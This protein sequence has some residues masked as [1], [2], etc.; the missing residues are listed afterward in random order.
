MGILRFCTIFLFL[1]SPVLIK[2]QQYDP[3]KVNK[4]AAALYEK[5]I[6]KAQEDDFKGGI[7]ILKEAVKID[8]RFLD[9]Y[10]S[11]AGMYGEMKDYDGAIENYLKA[12]SI[13]A[14]Y[15]KDYNLPFS[16]NLAGKGE[17]TKAL[18]SVNEFLTI[19]NLNSQSRLAGEFRQKSYQFAIEYS[20][21]KPLLD[22]KFEPKNMGDSVNS[23][24]NIIPRLRS[25]VMNS[26]L[27]DG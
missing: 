2:A 18:E 26:S 23:Y 1:I 20:K 25:V 10:L 9:A 19:P 15:F 12:K 4:K 8:P 27:H 13:D 22:Y 21:Q 7:V 5:A 17:F 16:I 3:A 6:A 14:E 11:I 24:R